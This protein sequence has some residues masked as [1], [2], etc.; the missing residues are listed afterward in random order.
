MGPDALRRVAQAFRI[1]ELR[2]TT[3]AH[4]LANID[5]PGYK[6]QRVFASLL[7]NELLQAN[8]RTD[9]QAGPLIQTGRTLDLALEGEG[10]LVVETAEGERWV[11]GGSFQLDESRMLVDAHGHRLLGESGPLVIPDGRVEIGPEGE[12]RVEGSVVGVLRLEKPGV[13]ASV[14][15]EGEGRWVVEGQGVAADRGQ[16]RVR[17]KWLEESNVDPVGALVE[18]IEIQRGVAALQRS[19]LVLDGVLERISNDLGKVR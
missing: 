13:G 4:N 7:E 10:F 3:V 1:W 9:L 18:M 14:R 19:V 11:R 15:R 2:Q 6:A 8:L 5:S 12:V 16:V 17:Q